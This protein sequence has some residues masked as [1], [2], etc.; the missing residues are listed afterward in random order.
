M[1]YVLF[2]SG[3]TFIFKMKH[4]IETTQ[5]QRNIPWSRTWKKTR[6]SLISSRRVAV[7]FVCLL[8]P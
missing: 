3:E 6:L 2:K 1:V 4:N 8:H 7:T 5:K